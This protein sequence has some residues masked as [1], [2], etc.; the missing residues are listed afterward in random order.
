LSFRGALTVTPRHPPCHSEAGGRGIS[1]ILRL[2]FA[3]AQNDRC[4][5]H[6]SWRPLHD[7]Y[8]LLGQLVQLVDQV[9][10]LAVGGVDL[11]LEGGLGGGGLGGG[12]LALIQQKR[13]ETVD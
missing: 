6:L 10:D 13:L 5:G 1:E 3:P 12:Q 2:R 9:V 11:T 8:L 4:G 7:P